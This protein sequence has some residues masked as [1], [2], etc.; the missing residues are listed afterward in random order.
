MKQAQKM[1]I[2]AVG[3]HPDDVEILMAGTLSKLHRA[4]CRIHI[5][6]V[7]TGDMGSMELRMREVASLRFQEATMS[8]RI[9]KATYESLGE[10]DLS[11]CFDN[12]TRAKAVELM[13]RADPDIVFTH[14]PQDYMPDHEM[15]SNLMWDGAF[16]A[17]VPNY[18]TGFPSPARPT[19]K[20]PYLFY[21]DPIEGKDRFGERIIPHFYVD[22]TDDMKTK[23]RMLAEHKSQR[24]WLRA[25]HGMDQY[26]LS[27]KEWS[28]HRGE[29]AGVRYAEAFRQHR[30]HP[31]PQDNILDKLIGV[32]H[33]E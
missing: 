24:S 26:I 1:K 8:A 29:E 15:T 33:K 9:L 22:T 11:I 18:E 27:M 21:A 31:F 4:G 16:S 20:I 2:L 32:L 12:P 6:T 30:G 25:Q 14:S 13:R 5:A 19:T 7:A 28:A 17:S 3:A 10:S 23:A